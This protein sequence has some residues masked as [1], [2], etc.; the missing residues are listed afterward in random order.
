M[1]ISISG[2]GGT[3]RNPHELVGT[4]SWTS[5]TT[6][7]TFN[8]DNTKYEQYLIYW[9]IDHNPSWLIT[10]ARFR[11]SGADITSN[12]YAFGTGWLGSS[13]TA[14]TSAASFNAA[15]GAS[16][17]NG[18]GGT[19]RSAIWM[20]GNGSAQE[21]HGWGHIVVPNSS[22]YN[23]HMRVCSTLIQNN[24]GDANTYN[25]RAFGACIATTSNNITGITIKS[26][27]GGSSRRGRITL[28]GIK[29]NP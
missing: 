4:T 3:S 26:I 23:P 17:P 22:A 9:W 25:E 24:S 29:K 15:T 19:S 28:I 6:S 14:G 16:S 2:T 12:T 18:T 13:A 21:T 11:T 20:A 5:N 8:F 27:D 1:S 7:V 10:A